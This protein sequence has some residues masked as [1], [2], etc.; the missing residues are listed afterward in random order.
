MNG[1]GPQ[2]PGMEK[3]GPVEFNHAISYVNKIKVFQSHFT[4]RPTSLSHFR[5]LYVH[6]ANDFTSLL[7]NRFQDKPEIYKQ[8]LEILQTYQ[9]ESKPIQDVYAQVTTLFNTAPDLLEDFKQFLPESA[10]QAKAAAKAAEDAAALAGVAQTPQPMHPARVDQKLPPV[11]NFPPPSTGKTASGKRPRPPPQSNSSTMVQTSEPAGQRPSIVPAPNLNKRAKISHTRGP[12]EEGIA[13]SP[14]LTPNVALPQP[15]PPTTPALSQ[16]SDVAFFDKVKK[17][18]SNKQTFAE[19]LKLCNLFT[20]DL[21]DKNVLVHKVNTFIGAN[22][23][24]MDFFK[25]FVNYGGPE[26]VIENRSRAPTGKVALSNCR[27]LGPSYRLLPKR[28]RMKPCS[29]R[30]EMCYSVLN[31]DWA[32]HPTWASEDSGF[33]AHRKNTFEE[34]LHRIEEE[35]HDYDF[36]IE[37]NQKVIQLLEPIGQTVL[38]MTPAELAQFR[39]P[40]NLGGSSPS[41]HKRILKKIYGPE[42]GAQVAQDLFRD[43]V[44]VLPTVLNRLKQKDQ[45]WRFTQR[46]WEKLW[47]A[48]TQA[49]Y[50]KSLDHMGLNIKSTDKK[51]WTTKNIVDNIRLK[52]EEQRL[53]RGK[54]IKAKIPRYQMAYEFKDEAV[55]VDAIRLAVLYVTNSATHTGVERDRIA[56]FLE[57][58]IPMFFDISWDKVQDRVGDISRGSPDEDMEDMAPAELTNGRGRRGKKSDL[59]RGVLDRGRNGVKRGVKE[60]S[61]AS[62]SRGSTPDDISTVDDDGDMVEPP[63]DQT[64]TEVTN[65][66]WLVTLPTAGAADGTQPLDAVELELTADKLFHRDYYNLYCNN[67]ILVFFTYF[68]TLYQ[69]LKALKDSEDEVEEAVRRARRPKPAKEIGLMDIRIPFFAED[70]GPDYYTRALTVMEEYIAGEMDQ[71]RYEDFFRTWYLKKGWGVYTLQELLKSLCRTAALC[72]GSD[73]KDK[74]PDILELFEQNRDKEETTYNTE[75]NLRKQVEKYVKND[76]MYMIRYVSSVAFLSSNVC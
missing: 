35:R 2:Q 38:Q 20:Q 67:T 55:L 40:P 4:F 45:E 50:L 54:G 32:S 10:A 23:E 7:Q 49:M 59:L 12:V 33:V 36:N 58:F 56:Q 46:E 61:A 24:L 13:V 73:N 3:R 11:G 28:E 27:G 6:R 41:I 16:Q 75:I 72:S 76:E 25:K 52:H 34:S 30:D 43:P 9:R 44:A 37:A 70:R 1:A 69:R 18:L 29:G 64:V 65:E 17:F 57:R 21:I 26:E 53:Q 22:S 15:L 47:H 71:S 62:G 63:E 14:T 68:Q 31:D 39:L 8:F 42:K 51:A 60:D 74:S 48:Q 19:F 5:S 66:R